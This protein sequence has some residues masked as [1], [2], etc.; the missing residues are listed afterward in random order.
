MSSLTVG[1]TISN[2]TTTDWSAP[3][4]SPESSRERTTSSRPK[5]LPE[6]SSKL[7]NK[8][9]ISAPYEHANSS[10]SCPFGSR[11]VCMTISSRCWRLRWDCFWWDCFRRCECAHSLFSLPLDSRLYRHPRGSIWA[12]ASNYCGYCICR[13]KLRHL[14]EPC[15]KIAL[16]PP[17]T[18]LFILRNAAGRPQQPVLAVGFWMN[19]VE[20]GTHF[21]IFCVLAKSLHFMLFFV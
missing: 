20:F 12:R 16:R 5:G 21:G 4:I 14:G 13:P 6:L 8:Y 1:F 3:R 18:S 17:L 19:W 7:S 11:R 15:W 9:R 10:P 2:S